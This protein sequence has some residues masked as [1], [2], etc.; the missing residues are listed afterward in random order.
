[1][2]QPKRRDLTVR[3][4][5]VNARYSGGTLSSATP[6]AYMIGFLRSSTLCIASIAPVEARGRNGWGRSV[7]GVAT[8]IGRLQLTTALRVAHS[9]RSTNFRGFVCGLSTKTRVEDARLPVSN[10]RSCDRAL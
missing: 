9:R 2:R 6:A 8:G 1:M 3:S 5:K 7:D 10:A 4:A